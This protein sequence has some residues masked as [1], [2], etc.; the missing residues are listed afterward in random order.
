MIYET[1]DTFPFANLTLC[2]PISSS[3]GF[4]IRYAIN[5]QSL[6]IQPLSLTSNKCI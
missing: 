2:K 5:E 3:G 4:F 6:Y 1:N